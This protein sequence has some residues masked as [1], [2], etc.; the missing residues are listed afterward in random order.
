MPRFCVFL[1]VAGCDCGVGATVSRCLPPSLCVILASDR[2]A[3]PMTRCSCFAGDRNWVEA[4]QVD[5]PVSY[6]LLSFTR[7]GLLL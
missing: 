4:S 3:V 2:L 5:E 7:R 6:V 1:V